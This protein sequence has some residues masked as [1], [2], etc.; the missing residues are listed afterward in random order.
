MHFA[1][2]SSI[3]RWSRASGVPRDSR[4]WFSV[5]LLDLPTRNPPWCWSDLLSNPRT[6]DWYLFSDTTCESIRVTEFPRLGLFCNP[7]QF[8]QEFDWSIL[9]RSGSFDRESP[10]QPVSEGRHSLEWVSDPMAIISQLRVVI[11]YVFV[12][13][14]K[15][16]CTTM[17]VPSAS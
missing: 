16:C 7:C 13:Y 3:K 11:A 14:T 6:S 12:W 1:L 2:V 10:F 9:E 4:G 15:Y 8:H 5:K 17:I